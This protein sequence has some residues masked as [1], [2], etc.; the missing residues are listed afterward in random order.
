MCNV[1]KMTSEMKVAE[2]VMDTTDAE[3]VGIS[4]NSPIKITKDDLVIEL[5]RD[6]LLISKTLEAAME[7]DATTSSI[8]ISST[9]VIPQH[10]T[11]LREYFIIMEGKEENAPEK[12]LRSNNPKKFLTK[13][14]YEF[15]APQWLAPAQVDIYQ[16]IHRN[17]H[18]IPSHLLNLK[19]ESKENKDKLQAEL[20][21]HREEEQKI[22]FDQLTTEEKV[23][24]EEA[25][26]NLSVYN[27]LLTAVSWLNI[28]QLLNCMLALIATLFRMN[29]REMDD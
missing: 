25:K 22:A 2:T 4:D 8:P 17:F 1:E 26:T 23:L 12:P 24:Y 19:E 16:R 20:R 14:Q 3:V 15:L 5:P 10:L 13:K 27:K 21:K 7:D 18:K 6:Y 29:Y 28:P 11:I 9:L